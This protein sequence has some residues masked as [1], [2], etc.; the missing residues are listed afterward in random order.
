MIALITV[1]LLTLR[2]AMNQ[3][4]ALRSF[5]AAE[6]M[7]SKAQKASLIS[8]LKYSQTRDERY[9][10]AF[11]KDLDVPMGDHQARLELVKEVPDR[12]KLRDGFLRGRIH[13]DDID[14]VVNIVRRF[15]W[16]SYLE[17]ALATWSEGDRVLSLYMNEAEALHRAIQSRANQATIQARLDSIEKLNSELTVLQDRFSYVLGEGSRWMTNLLITSILI[18]VL[19]IEGTSLLL[20]V[21]FGRN[22]R[23]SLLDLIDAAKRIGQGTFNLR[24]PVRSKDEVGQLASAINVMA[25]E[26]EETIGS[27]EV[28]ERASKTK[29][30][31]LANMSHEIRTPLTAILGFSEVLKGPDLSAAERNEFLDIIS[32]N[33][34]SL[35]RLID[36]ILDL[37]KVEAG[38]LVIEIVDLSLPTLL[39]DLAS[40]FKARLL[41]RNLNLKLEID[42]SARKAVRTDATRL[43]QILTNLIGNA[44]KFTQDGTITVR[45]FAIKTKDHE[46]IVAQ[47]IDSGIGLKPEQKDRLFKLFS[48]ADETT[49]RKFGGTGLGLVLSRKLAERLGGTVQLVS[50]EFGKG[51]TFEVRF[52][53]NTNG[54]SVPAIEAPETSIDQIKLQKVLIAEDT[55][56]T[57]IL[58]ARI[59]KKLKIE[60]DI[61]VNGLEAVAHAKLYRYDLIILDIQM[62]EMDGYEAFK[63][64]KNLGVVTPIVAL[65]AHALTSERNK[66]IKFG[67]HSHLAK[68]F[69]EDS[70]RALL[71]NQ[72]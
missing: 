60:A 61:V 28:A 11:L 44:I 17:N 30:M 70:L 25:E 54:Y 66:I 53:N 10:Q 33:G 2:F 38:G 57:R 35:S 19:T 59:F 46:E 50:S 65:T 43:R 18:L 40:L 41:E 49:S 22:L 72:T 7:W 39:Q 20:T 64:I 55:P 9:Y 8:I 4:S 67:F 47:V 42:S 24:V 45:A 37:S 13:K 68:P 34:L 5:V 52:A 58:L 31:F 26:L 3:M 1:E 6:G 21:S 12:T 51:S 16:V 69:N 29:T 14:D 48:Q 56:D 36:D 71:A 63:A 15:Y 32:R 27:K 62:P 23:R